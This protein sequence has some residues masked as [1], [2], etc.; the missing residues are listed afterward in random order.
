MRLILTHSTRLKTFAK[1]GWHMRLNAEQGTVVIPDPSG[2][3]LLKN[4]SQ[5]CLK[6]WNGVVSTSVDERKNA[7]QHLSQGF[8]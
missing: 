8:I 1:V 5:K 3:G 2:Q 4:I 6:H 7:N